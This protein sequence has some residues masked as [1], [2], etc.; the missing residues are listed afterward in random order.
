MDSPWLHH[1][2]SFYLSITI[3]ISQYVLFI[4]TKI[5]GFPVFVT[6]TDAILSLYFRF[7]DLS[8][9]TVDLDDQTTMHFWTAN[10]RRFNKPGLVLIHGCGGN[11]RW[12]FVRQVGP[13]SQSFNLYIPDL[14]FFGKSFTN[15]L[16]RTDV[17][18]AK[19]VCEGL[20]R[21][22]VERFSMYAISYGGFV[23]YRMA[24]IYPDSVE[25][26]VIVSSGIG[27]TEEQKVKHMRK[28]GRN[29]LDLLLPEK[30]DD[31][32][33]LVNLSMY[34]RNPFE[35]VP[36]FFLRE[37]INVMCKNYRKEKQELLEHLLAKKAD[38]DPPIITQ[39]TLLI[40]GDQDNVFP[41]LL[42]HQLQRRLGPKSK[43]EIIKDTGHAAN[44]E[45][46]DSV[47]DLIKSFVLGSSKVHSVK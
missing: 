25:K 37:F 11:S 22:G 27:C 36:D 4:L 14:L 20:K 35:W 43:L 29:V 2:L 12:Q 18:Q 30:P 6:L 10:H 8:P 42:A 7:C 46:P 45:S 17:F 26:V 39:E 41:L 13:L 9:C 23:A 15:R 32:R 38:S 44:I 33:L 21:L 19:C 3:A 34:K 31:L 16:D 24:E 28:I 1:F 47:N 40:W 5:K